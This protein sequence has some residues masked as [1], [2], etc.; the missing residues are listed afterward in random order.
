[1][2]GSPGTTDEDPVL[3]R[4]V[5]DQGFA[6]RTVTDVTRAGG[7]EGDGPV[8]GLRASLDPIRDSGLPLPLETARQMGKATGRTIVDVLGPML[9]SPEGAIIGGASLIPGVAPALWTGLAAHGAHTGGRLTRQAYEGEKVDKGE[10]IAAGIEVLGGAPFFGAFARQA[11]GGIQ[12][13]R[14]AARAS[15]TMDENFAA[16]LSRQGRERSARDAAARAPKLLGPGQYE[17]G[18]ATSDP[19]VPRGTPETRPERLIPSPRVPVATAGDRPLGPPIPVEDAALRERRRVEATPDD[20]EA[21]RTIRDEGSPYPRRLKDEPVDRFTARARKMRDRDQDAAEATNAE[22]AFRDWD[23][24]I[25]AEKEGRT[26]AREEGGAPKR[27]FSKVPLE[28]L[29]AEHQRIIEGLAQAE[30]D[31]AFTGEQRW[32]AYNALPPAERTGRRRVTDDDRVGGMKGRTR[33][34]EDLPTGD[35]LFDADDLAEKRKT[36]GT[37]NSRTVVRAQQ[38]KL[39]ARLEEEIVKR[40]GGVA[41]EVLAPVG[42]GVAGAAAGAALDDEDPMRGAVAGGA[43]G[44]SLGMLAAMKARGGT[45]VRRAGGVSRGGTRDGY[46]GD[47]SYLVGSRPNPR[48][49]DAET[50]ARAQGADVRLAERR[51]GKPDLRPAFDAA[52]RRTMSPVLRAAEGG[53][54]SAGETA[55]RRMEIARGNRAGAVGDLEKVG[56]S[57]SPMARGEGKAIEHVGDAHDAP[58]AVDARAKEMFEGL[59][60]RRW[61]DAPEAER[62]NYRLS[63]TKNQKTSAAGF[64]QRLRSRTARAINEAPFK[65]GTAEQWKAALS[66][67]V[68][69]S[70]REFTGLD[71][72]LEENAGKVL[73]QAQVAEHFNANRI[74]IG[75]VRL[76][77]AAKNQ[78]RLNEIERQSTAMSQ[79][80]LPDNRMRDEA[81]WHGLMRE[82]DTLVAEDAGALPRYQQY[83][84]P[85]GQNYREVVLT[86]PNDSIK[87]PL[88]EQN[89]ALNNFD[90]TLYRNDFRDQRAT[91]VLRHEIA[92]APRGKPTSDLLR[93]SS[94]PI[95]AETMD[96]AARFRRAH[97]MDERAAEKGFTSPHW[98]G[99]E[100]PLVHVRMNDRVLPSGEKALFLEEIQSDWHQRGRRG[101]Y[102]TGAERAPRLDAIDARLSEIQDRFDEIPT[103][104]AERRALAD[105]QSHLTDER[106]MLEAAEVRR[107]AGVPD[108]PLKKTPEWATLGL[109]R[110]VDEAIETG[111]DRVVWTTGE[112]QARRYDLSKV[113]DEVHY[114]P[115]TG[116]LSARKD[117]RAVHDGRYDARALPD[118]IG[119]E[120]ADKLLATP[121]KQREVDGIPLGSELHS[122]TGLD[123]KV[124]GEGMKGFYDR[125]LP[126]AV[127]DYAKKM[128]VK[129]EVEPVQVGAARPLEVNEVREHADEI[130]NE[131]DGGQRSRDVATAMEKLADY[132]ESG[133]A[134]VGWRSGVSELH[135]NGDFDNFNNPRA[136]ERELVS[137]LESFE[138]VAGEGQ[139][140]SPNLSFRITPELK[141]KVKAE[142]Q[143][144]GMID[145][146]LLGSVGA[147][148][149]GAVAGSRVGDTP[150]ERRRNAAIGGAVGALGAL[151][152][153]KLVR[154]RLEGKA[155]PGERPSARAEIAKSAKSP[156]RSSGGAS[157]ESGKLFNKSLQIL[158]PEGFE[159]WKNEEAKLIK[160]GEKKVPVSDDA[161]R[162]MAKTADVDRINASDAKKLDTVELFALG[163]RI[164]E[165]RELYANLMVES[166]KLGPTLSIEARADHAKEMDAVLSRLISYD[167]TLNR[168][169]SEQGRGLRILGRIAARAG[170]LESALGVARRALGTRELGDD[171]TDALA[172]VMQTPGLSIKERERQIAMAIREFQDKGPIAAIL[173][174]RRWSMLTA[175]ATHAVNLTGNVAEAAAKNLVVTPV[176]A[177]IDRVISA[178]TGTE[179]TIT[180]TGKG[181]GYAAGLRRGA[182]AVNKRM[183]EGINPD[184]PLNALNLQRADYVKSFGL[185]KDGS[186]LKSLAPGARILQKSGDVVY[187]IMG[188]TDAP[189][190][191]AAL[192]SSLMERAGLRAMREGLTAG[193]P[194]WKPRIRELM[195][196]DQVSETDATMAVVEALDDTFK[197]PTAVGRAV[198]S[199]GAPAQYLVP[200]AN[201]PTNLIRK[202]L[203]A[204][205][206]IGTALTEVQV[207]QMRERLRKL[208]ASPEEIGREVR[209]KRITGATKQLTTG[210]GMVGLGFLWTKMGMLSGDYVEP[211]ARDD[212]ERD[213][214]GERQLTGQGPLTLRVGDTAHSLSGFAQFAPLL[215]MGHAL[216]LESALSEDDPENVVPLGTRVG[217]IA[218]RAAAA[219]LRT[220]REFPLIQGVENLSRVTE[221]VGKYLGREAA[222]L[223]PYGAGVAVA[224]RIAD[225]VARRE[226][227]SFSAAIKERIPGLRDDLPARVNP[228]GD[229]AVRPGAA[230]ALAAPTRPQHLMTGPVA[231]ELQR[232]KVFPSMPTRLPSESRAAYSARVQTEGPMV[233]SILEE[234][235]QAD[236]YRALS[237]QDQ[238]TEVRKTI[239]AMRR[240]LSQTRGNVPE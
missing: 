132:M 13:L 139:P 82:R 120:A 209:R 96:A 203:E 174:I 147:G 188:A 223:I 221:G 208:G 60:K 212:A 222:S 4:Q 172:K 92:M 150:E 159:L 130:R 101:G 62:R 91:A 116:N 131:R 230:A 81:G 195:K 227:D 192:R 206:G 22:G 109:M 72:F 126:N 99:I 151:A 134:A 183:F 66:K 127:K 218:E 194:E 70:E 33:Q 53:E 114:N 215:A 123:L 50:I 144:L 3:G 175:P 97:N 49:L 240:V 100:N 148:A 204:T 27:D 216:A 63:Q 163:N 177:A 164:K 35:D 162:Q 199:L 140:P 239:R 47:P 226:T 2:T 42:G 160:A 23:E 190:Y 224:A 185:D 78:V 64:P 197:T 225:P 233:K 112:Q 211:Q 237:L 119:K 71:S 58:D 55:L 102:G 36:L 124:G 15:A 157:D 67:N 26:L 117:G 52:E 21:Y 40:R 129:L 74:Q 186:W 38:E 7:R 48:P 17:M 44:F 121:R 94:A 146:A 141:A 122:L 95:T 31:V 108:A 143:P 56:G 25:A 59:T 73:T 187:G 133:D 79:D 80:R 32:E 107:P 14:D 30:G 76:G 193:S 86:T 18:P 41:P 155:P 111:A 181:A 182:R 28:D 161:I 169:G 201:T 196:P 238:R 84:E 19:F 165:D 24:M 219:T 125:M 176:A 89:E 128:G 179:R 142:G 90:Q 228:L 207:R 152:A 65:K 1:M 138:N 104:P 149:V 39:A 45:T 236:A 153:A 145:P 168:A 167:R 184:D 8:A 12:K 69:A 6:R 20:I 189:F 10:A 232:I 205:P 46:V 11:G 136:V 213:E 88:S 113:V 93:E 43:A 5:L 85:G 154:A 9:A 37:Y 210:A 235:F 214:A 178:A 106:A 115:S 166:E 87:V 200:F 98:P 234:L 173:D 105:E 77:R 16:G 137:A 220:V 202:A 217:S 118:V 75:E 57:G 171:V 135:A 158:D 51:A 68:P 110:A 34:M 191:Q 54:G 83:V 29:E 170:T 103:D 61:E 198:E 180:T 229:V 156:I 231:D